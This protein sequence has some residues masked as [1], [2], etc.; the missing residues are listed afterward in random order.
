[1]LA[2]QKNDVLEVM[3]GIDQ[4][5]DKEGMPIECAYCGGKSLKEVDTDLYDG[6]TIGWEIV[7]NDCGNTIGYFQ[8]GYWNP[9][10]PRNIEE[11][12]KEA[13]K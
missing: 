9:D 11:L 1:M 13:L 4:F 5:Y 7:C 6:Q 8:S 3:R 10:Y 2:L 12:L